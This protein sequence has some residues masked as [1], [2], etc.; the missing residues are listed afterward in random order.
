MVLSLKDIKAVGFDL[1][2]TLYPNSKEIDNRIRNEI[3]KRI[4]E[5]KPELK[6]IEK[7]KEIYEKKYL[8]IGSW[9]KVLGGIG[10]KNPE[11][12]MYRCM[13]RADITDLLEEDEK[14]IKILERINDKYY[15]FLITSSPEDLG[16]SKLRKIGIHLSLFDYSVFGISKVNTNVF[17]DFLKQ[18]KYSSKEHVY[19]G[20]LKSDILPAKSLGMKTIAVGMRIKEADIY[21]KNIHDIERLFL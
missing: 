4:L 5:K 12:V 6:S 1:D 14:L 8:G 21:I 3:A 19:I 20:D 15:T 10:I 9:T 16:L 7:T 17:Y 13:S 11:K 18:S 2:N